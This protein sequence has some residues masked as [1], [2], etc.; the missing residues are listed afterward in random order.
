MRSDSCLQSSKAS[1]S[2]SSA[3]TNGLSFNETQFLSAFQPAPFSND[4]VALQRLKEAVY[5][6]IRIEDARAG[7]VKR[8]IRVYADGIYDLFHAGQARQ[9][10]QAKTM[11]PN[12]YLIVGGKHSY[13][14]FF[15]Y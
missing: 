2:A 7:K 4:E 13:W 9:F 12:T 11:L 10:M 6:P 8:T 3:S 5:E 14:N 15:Y 1:G